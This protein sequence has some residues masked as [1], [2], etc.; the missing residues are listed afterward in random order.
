M[1]LRMG[2]SIFVCFL[3]AQMDLRMGWSIFVCFLKA[4]MDLRM[5]SSS[6]QL[7]CLSEGKLYIISDYRRSIIGIVFHVLNNL[8]VLG[9]RQSW[10]IKSYQSRTGGFSK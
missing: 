5:V 10:T 2:W 4:Q 3:K 6:T 9:A 7:Y 1:D 8:N